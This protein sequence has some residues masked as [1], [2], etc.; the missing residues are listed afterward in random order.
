M[1]LH[2]VLYCYE[3]VSPK[4]PTK[5]KI[6]EM[7]MKTSQE[8]N[9][10][11]KIKSRSNIHECCA[12]NCTNMGHFFFVS[13]K[14]GNMRFC[15]EQ[16][17]PPPTPPLPSLFCTLGLPFAGLFWSTCF[18]STPSPNFFSAYKLFYIFSIPI[19]GASQ[20][21]RDN[22]KPIVQEH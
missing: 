19:N 13:L 8:K 15:C 7:C 16:P 5:L 6:L 1:V 11:L 18:S 10:E 17:P 4:L 12:G 20:H 22:T 21:P 9:L 14:Y 2:Y 3:K